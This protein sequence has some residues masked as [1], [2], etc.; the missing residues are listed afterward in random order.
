MADSVSVPEKKNIVLAITGSIAAYKGCELARM[1]VSRGYNVRVIMTEAAQKFVGVDSL[2]AITGNAVMTSLWEEHEASNMEHISLGDWADGIVIAPATAD[3][4]AKF[5]AGFADSALHA[6]LL[7]SRA[8]VLVC[9]AMNVNMLEHPAT[10]E[11]IE[12]LKKR[13]VTFVDPE[14]GALACG[15]NGS[16]RLASPDEIFFHVR[17][18]LS[19]QDLS[20]KRV[21]ITTGA[22]REYMDP[23]RFISN[24]SS[25]KMGVALAREAFRRG[26]HVTLVHGPITS[27]IPAMIECVPVITAQQMRDAVLE[28][29][30]AE[31]DRPEIVIMAAAVADFKPT[32]TS[33]EKLK[34]S[35]GTAAAPI[36]LESNPDILAEV[37]ALRGDEK[38]PL[39]IGFAV[40]TGEVENLLAEAQRKLA[41]KHADLI[42]A[43][44]AD[45]AFDLDTN[46]V[47][48]VDAR[49]S[50]H[51]IAT[52]FKSRVAQKIIDAVQK[53]E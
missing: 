44:L 53:L 8:P 42:I 48:I 4:I 40:E 3:C 18:L 47:W 20:G 32:R 29:V 50:S 45:E 33:G 30:G 51:E 26:A 34:K 23:V 43:N 25:G 13:G 14:D 15:W 21:L 17:R 37:G 2:H 7:A 39:L 9:P 36:S 35:K 49:G 52:T 22:T 11:N 46:R 27:R 41:V 5:A 6:V 12:I 38:R 31:D 24:R 1:L 19:V 16:G 10:Q 28:R